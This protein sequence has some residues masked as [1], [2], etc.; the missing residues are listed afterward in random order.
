MALHNHMLV[1]V[2]AKNPPKDAKKTTEWLK[3]LVYSIGMKIPQGPFALT[4]I[5]A[6]SYLLNKS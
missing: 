2:F 4:Y 3:N 6:R 5:L 1:N